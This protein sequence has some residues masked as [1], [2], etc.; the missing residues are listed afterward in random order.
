MRTLQDTLGRPGRFLRTVRHLRAGQIANR[1]ARRFARL[2]ALDGQPPDLCAAMSAWRNCPGRP[3]SMLSPNSFRFIGLDAELSTAADW[4]RTDRAKLWLYNLHYFDD[5][6]ADGAAERASWHRA[7][8]ERW[9][10]E[11]P[12]ASG[13]GW[14]PYPL[15]IRIVNWIAWILGGSVPADPM[16]QSLAVQV[17]VLRA[18]LEF[19]LLGNH[20][21]ANAKA[22]IFAGCFFAGPEAD[23]W[24][25]TGLALLDAELREQI[26]SDGG[27]F[28]LSPMYHAIILEDVLDLIQLSQI[29]PAQLAARRQA[30][31]DLASRMLT[32]LATMTHADGE[33]A[34]F[35]DAASGIAR[36]H[37]DLSAYAVRFGVSSEHGAG[38]LRQLAASGYVRLQAGPFC[39]IFDAAEIGPSY[40]PG[41]GHADVLALEASLD[42]HR[43]ITNGG[44]STYAPGRLRDD[45][46]ATA[47]HAAVEIDGH[48]SSEVWAS[49]RVG[50][51]AHP[52]GVACGTTDNGVW[53]EASHDGYRWLPGRPIHQRRVQLSPA[54]LS[55]TDCIKGDGLHAVIGRFPLHPMVT[56]VSPEPSGWRL[57]LTGGRVVRVRVVGAQQ[58]FLANGYYAPAFGQRLARPVLVWRCD[59]PLPL[60]VEMRFEL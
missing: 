12:P 26:L 5:L 43:L 13:N 31:Q 53:A 14:E 48:S 10:V 55:V 36:T 19:H 41:H 27:H 51:R 17:R 56:S 24:R 8:I 52:F 50:R 54:A 9:R 42:G 35:N 34:F 38:P 16:L 28:E 22:L 46:R 60:N 4:N 30:W 37:L 47:S 58:H 21:L 7:L 18:T 11:N 33:V 49:F 39:V 57:E 1:I 3:V 15:S 20:L 2:P 40:L 59:G 45:E 44:T 25:Q 29:F 6:R 23:A 32:W